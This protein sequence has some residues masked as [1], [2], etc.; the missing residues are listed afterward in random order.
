MAPNSLA[1]LPDAGPCSSSA[2]TGPL[3]DRSACSAS[4]VDTSATAGDGPR[5]RSGPARRA[6]RARAKKTL[7]DHNQA[8]DRCLGYL[9]I[10]TARVPAGLVVSKS[11][12]WRMRGLP[13][14]EACFSYERLGSGTG[15]Q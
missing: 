13:L 3:A 4:T 7:E 11:V 10:C 5:C 9:R 14:E 6:A 15:I 2:G 12:S 8:L 1:G